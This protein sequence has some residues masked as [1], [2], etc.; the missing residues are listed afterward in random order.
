MKIYRYKL[1]RS[2]KKHN[3]PSCSK[4]RFVKYI[5]EETGQYLP[6]HYGRCDREDECNYHNPPPPETKTVFVEFTELHDYSEKAYKIKQNESFY[7]IPKSLVR[8]TLEHGFYIDEYFFTDE[9]ENKPRYNANDIKYF[10]YENLNVSPPLKHEPKAPAPIYYFDF[11]T[12]KATLKDY[13][14]NIFIQNLLHNVSFPLTTHAV[15]KIIEL[16]RL[17]T[18]SNNYRAG[19][20]TFPFID[21]NQNVR[22]I[23]VKEFNKHNS[24]KDKGTDFL[25]SMIERHYK[26]KG[27]PPPEWIENYN[28]NEMKV[29]CLFGEHLLK[30]YPNNPIALV[31]AP[32]T[33]IYGTLYFGSPDNPK[34]L[35]WLAVYSK[36][37]FKLDRVKVLEGR[38]I[39]V[40]PDLS[41]DGNTFDLWNDKAKEFQKQMKNTTF[42]TFDLLERIGTTEQK[43]KG[44]DIADILIKHDWRKYRKPQNQIVTGITKVSVQTKQF[45]LSKSKEESK[46]SSVDLSN[47]YPFEYLPTISLDKFCKSVLEPELN[48]SPE[49]MIK[50]LM[51]IGNT[52]KSK[53][54]GI[55]ERIEQS[56][57]HG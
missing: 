24:T 53:A 4:K 6:D 31:E 56:R 9:L 10:N 5:D 37:T 35:L 1:D 26:R 46:T 34:N 2:S 8:E 36:S 42:K 54:L 44:L 22:T 27:N 21:I 7:F 29:S 15:T 17:G 57:Q 16:F 39:V 30:K 41:K 45:F 40:F 11:E 19:A 47:Y 14:K 49:T 13:D 38:K 20:I 33:A 28:K 25:H 55:Y 52:E 43:N 12:F 32:K 3:C 50:K 23:Q 51:I 48:E 18:I